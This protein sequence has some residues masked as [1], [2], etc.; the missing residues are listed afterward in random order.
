MRLKRT[1]AAGRAAM[2]LVALLLAALA[3]LQPVD[4]AAERALASH[5]IRQNLFGAC[6]VSPTE[7]WVAGDL[8]RVL[9]TSDG[10]KTWIKQE[11]A[12]H[13]PFLSISCT[14]AS[15]AWLSSRH[16]RIYRTTDGG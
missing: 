12:A 10:G 1:R 3:R 16:G 2:A 8:G 13:E 5:E 9:R 15:H 6:F 7:G 14:D 4:G 11:V